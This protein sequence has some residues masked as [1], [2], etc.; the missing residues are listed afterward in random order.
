MSD[1]SRDSFRSGRRGSEPF[2]GE[3]PP[4]N[5]AGGEPVRRPPRR[6]LVYRVYGFM[7]VLSIAIMAAL[8]IVPRYTRSPRYLEPHA[9]LVQYLVERWAV[10]HQDLDEV[11]AR[12]E[13]RL[14][15][16]LSLYDASGKLLRSTIDPPSRR[17]PP[18]RN[19]SSGPHC[20][21]STGGGSWC[22]ATTAG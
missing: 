8:V 9:A 21:R 1:P 3:G 2:R 16:K 10:R 19:A 5:D 22:A 11:I 18:T 20:G 6:R 14:R 12:I 13:P 4:R 15:G 17:R 7:A